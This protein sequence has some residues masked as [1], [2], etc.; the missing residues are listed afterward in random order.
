[1][2]TFSE[3]LLPHMGNLPNTGGKVCPLP[4]QLPSCPEMPL[5]LFS[6]C[7]NL[8]PLLLP[9]QLPRVHPPNEGGAVSATH[10]TEIQQ[11]AARGLGGSLQQQGHAGEWAGRG[12]GAGPGLG[13]GPGEVG[14]AVDRGGA[15]VR[16][17][18]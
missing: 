2:Q 14:R 3:S 15:G 4:K 8:P 10:D 5:R 18:G 17:R 13:A 6:S 12:Q 7:S 9:A 16:G 11:H 1:M